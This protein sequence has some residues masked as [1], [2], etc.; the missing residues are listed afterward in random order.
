MFSLQLQETFE[1]DVN[2]S[3]ITDRS[4]SPDRNSMWTGFSYEDSSGE[5]DP[6][7]Y[8]SPYID[9][10]TATF[11]RPFAGPTQPM[12]LPIQTI[13]NITNIN[14]L[15]SNDA[16]LLLPRQNFEIDRSLIT[17]L[18]RIGEGAFGLVAKA[19]LLEENSAGCVTV[20]VKKRIT[21]AVKMLKGEV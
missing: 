20:A 8:P 1:F 11:F 4:W 3:E 16:P 21:V 14:A 5:Y 18:K 10:S 17:N 9:A 7:N 6:S 12:Q 19:N 13:P 2:S 15:Q